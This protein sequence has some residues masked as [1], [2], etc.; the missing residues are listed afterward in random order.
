MRTLLTRASVFGTFS[1]LAGLF[2]A[3]VAVAA[4]V[5]GSSSTNVSNIVSYTQL[6]LSQPAGVV[7][8]D[9]LLANVTVNSGASTPITAPSGWTLIKQ[10][11]NGNDITVATYYKVAGN[12]EPSNYSWTI[13]K[14]TKAIGGITRVNGVD[15]AN[16]ID[17]SSGSTGKG[18]SA[19]APSV[20]TSSV[21]EQIVAVYAMDWGLLNSGYFATPLGM[22]ENYDVTNTPAGPS[23]AMDSVTQATTGA[24][25]SKTS[26]IASAI[27]PNW[28]AQTIALRPAPASTLKNGLVSYWKFDELSGDAVDASG[29]GYTL[30][31]YATTPYNSGLIN[32]AADFGS[33][34]TSQ[35]LQTSSNLGIT[36]GEISMSMWFKPSVVPS[37]EIYL[38]MQQRNSVSKEI[39][40]INY[41]DEGGVKTVYV[42]RGSNNFYD[43]A[44]ANMALSTSTWNHIVLTYDS[45]TLRLYVNGSEVAS[46]A[47]TASG[48]SSSDSTTIG[49]N[50]SGG[51][52]TQG[53]IDEAGMWHKALSSGEVTTLYNGGSGIQYPF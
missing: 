36:G 13:Q 38:L 42:S 46:H 40:S 50:E 47:S 10:T 17:T 41:R 30:T 12:A 18:K 14:L 32:N 6:S 25:G 35:Y 27:K 31:N 37:N 1:I 4:I 45:T 33:S 26:A 39:Y 15:T 29:N 48:G 44:T 23:L 28:V 20:T 9:L 16:P 24:S 7:T 11:S 43:T 3:S 22:T 19:V 21:N 49:S 52:W 2:F 51:S 5:A 8:G 34:N 53:K